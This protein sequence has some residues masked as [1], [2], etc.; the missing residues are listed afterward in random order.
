[1]LFLEMYY[2]ITI[3]IECTWKLCEVES[4]VYVK[5]TQ[6]GVWMSCNSMK[7]L[8]NMDINY[9]LYYSNWIKREKSAFI[10]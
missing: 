10:K 2:R 6:Y 9:E 5:K 3:I 1:M 7:R 4:I 8:P